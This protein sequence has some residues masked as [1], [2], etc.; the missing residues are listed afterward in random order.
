MFKKIVRYF[1]P[2][3]WTL[4]LGGMAAIAAGFIFGQERN[5]LSL[6]SSL[7]GVTLIIFN[8]KGNV[9]GQVFAICFSVLYGLL[10]YTKAYYGEMIIYFALMTPIHIAS[11]VIWLKNLNKDAKYLEVKINTVSAR[12]YAVAG[13]CTVGLTVAFYYVLKALNTDNLIISTISLVT[14]LAA[15]YLMLRR[16]EFFSVCFVLNDVILIIMWSLKLSTDGISVL[17][18]VLCFSI[19][20]IDDAYC[21]LSWRKLKFSQ[22][23]STQKQEGQDGGPNV[24]HG[25]CQNEGQYDGQGGCQGEGQG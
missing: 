15:A 19:F 21:Y 16:S 17:P 2:F 22:R 24:S 23:V 11:I 7:F 4:W 8:A 14:S 13:V 20:L 25:G 18:S 6:F 3:E 9:W 10:S 12:E 1:T 5:L